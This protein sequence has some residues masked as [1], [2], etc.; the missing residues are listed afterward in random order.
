MAVDASG[1]VY[2]ADTFNSQI[3]EIG[4]APS[5]TSFSPAS[6]PVG[7]VVTIFGTGFLGA[8]KV[9]VNGV[10]ATITKDTATKIKI[11]VPAGATTGNIK[12]V[13][14]VGIVK[15]ATVFTVT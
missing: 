13:T 10:T 3:V 11:M 4:S 9:K 12:V 5:I 6:G 15:T 8:S 1:N 7:T 14:R 2:V